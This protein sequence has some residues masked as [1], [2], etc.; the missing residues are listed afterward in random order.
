[1][2]LGTEAISR[3]GQNGRTQRGHGTQN[4]KHNVWAQTV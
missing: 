4:Q 1:M 3:A 2:G